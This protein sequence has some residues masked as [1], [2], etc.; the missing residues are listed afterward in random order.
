M[1]EKKIQQPDLPNLGRPTNPESTRQRLINMAVGAVLKFPLT[2]TGSIRATC[3][4]IAL[5]SSMKYGT[6]INKESQELIVTRLK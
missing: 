5:L 4:Q 3:S 2:A 6:L 1:T